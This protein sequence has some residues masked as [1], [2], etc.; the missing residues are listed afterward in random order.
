MKKV[1]KG[2][3]I[4][5]ITFFMVGAVATKLDK[6]TDEP[7]PWGQNTTTITINA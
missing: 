5:L 3:S 1:L 6:G 4:F 7:L 2:L